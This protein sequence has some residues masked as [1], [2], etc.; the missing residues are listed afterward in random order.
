MDIVVSGAREDRCFQGEHLFYCLTCNKLPGVKPSRARL[1]LAAR[2]SHGACNAK[3]RRD[4]LSLIQ[5][6]FETSGDAELARAE[7][8][9]AVQL[10]GRCQRIL[11]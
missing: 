7:I 10:T 11:E 4:S 8:G 6:P 1:S 2:E 5:A 3:M 9:A